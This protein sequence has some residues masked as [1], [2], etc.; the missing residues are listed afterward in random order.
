M[1]AEQYSKLR[2]DTPHHEK[3][4]EFGSPGG[5]TNINNPDFEQSRHNPYEPCRESRVRSPDAPEGTVTSGETTA[6]FPGCDYEV[7]RQWWLYVPQQYDETKAANLMVCFD[8]EVQQTVV[9]TLVMRYF[10]GKLFSRNVDSHCCL[11][12]ANCWN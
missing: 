5:G 10:F 7:T 9:E 11:I 6:P 8:G 2:I 3:T 12:S 4:E 1:D